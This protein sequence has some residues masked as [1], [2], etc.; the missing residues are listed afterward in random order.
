LP[1]SAMEMLG[2]IGR[3]IKENVRMIIPTFANEPKPCRFM[4][5]PPQQSESIHIDT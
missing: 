1:S 5:K 3:R 2:E 4:I